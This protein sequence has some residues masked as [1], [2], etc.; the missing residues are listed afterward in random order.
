MN[1]AV[2]TKYADEIEGLTAAPRCHMYLMRITA[3]EG[4]SE[5]ALAVDI[6]ST[7]LDCF[8]VEGSA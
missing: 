2:I 3:A 8:P 4:G 7:I 6:A 1:A 5:R